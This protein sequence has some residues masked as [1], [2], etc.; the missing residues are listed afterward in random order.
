MCSPDMLKKGQDPD[1]QEPFKLRYKSETVPKS[2]RSRTLIISNSL[3][4]FLERSYFVTFLFTAKID[5]FFKHGFCTVGIVTTSLLALHFNIA[6]PTTDKMLR[7][8]GSA[9]LLQ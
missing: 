2:F 4:S 1:P 7:R 6:T 8:N 9:L 5:A 3:N